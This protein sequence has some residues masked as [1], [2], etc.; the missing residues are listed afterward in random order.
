MK[1]SKTRVLGS[2]TVCPLF[3]VNGDP[4]GAGK[5]FTTSVVRLSAEDDSPDARRGT[6]DC[7]GQSQRRIRK[8]SQYQGQHLAAFGVARRR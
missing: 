3:L 8:P 4:G 5:S 1:K 7:A 2:G 6:Q